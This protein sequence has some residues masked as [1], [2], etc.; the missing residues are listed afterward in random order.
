MEGIA[1]RISELLAK[2]RSRVSDYGSGELKE[3]GIRLADAP[4]RQLS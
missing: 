3:D 1:H 4:T 2:G